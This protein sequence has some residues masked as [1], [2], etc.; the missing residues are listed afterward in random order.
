M[1]KLRMLKF[2]NVKVKWNICSSLGANVKV[3]LDLSNYTAKA[4]LRNPTGVDTS[5]F[6]KKIDLTRLKSEVD[7]L[8]VGEL[9]TNPVDFK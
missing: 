6:A 7:K 8:G 4:D 2:V 5:D 3:E 1:C 9:E